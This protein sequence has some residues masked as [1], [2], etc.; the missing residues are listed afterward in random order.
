[1][2]MIYKAYDNTEFPTFKECLSYEL[3]EL[4]VIFI[5]MNFNK[6]EDC[7][8]A[9]YIYAP[10]RKAASIIRDY[11]ETCGVSSS[12]WSF[13]DTSSAKYDYTPILFIWDE[14]IGT[15]TPYPYNDFAK[16]M[17]VIND[18]KKPNCKF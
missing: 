14:R 1:M 16:L 5:D 10:D 9:F 17:E 11:D 18:N 15:Y 12:L 7:E 4:G 8:R 6:T 13:G 3:K 2:E